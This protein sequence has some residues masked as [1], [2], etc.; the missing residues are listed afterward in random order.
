MEG[1]GAKAFRFFLFYLS[2][3]HL[4]SSLQLSLTLSLFSIGIGI[5]FSSPSS[6]SRS[7]REDLGPPRLDLRLEHVAVG[8]EDQVAVR[9]P[10]RGPEADELEQV[11]ED[12]D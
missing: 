4:R 2:S 1:G 6:S 12:G 10:A 7:L 11:R 8:A 5:I 3:R 9:E